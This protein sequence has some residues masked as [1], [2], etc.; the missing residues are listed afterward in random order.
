M[1]ANIIHYITLVLALTGAIFAFGDQVQVISFIAPDIAHYWPFVLAL[2][3]VVDRIGKILLEFL[4]KG[5]EPKADSGLTRVGV[6]N[7]YLPVVA[8]IASLLLFSGCATDP[9]GRRYYVGPALTFGGSYTTPEGA[10]YGADVH[11]DPAYA[12]QK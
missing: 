8:V 12:K 7:P 3:T 6:K 10:R 2:A 4:A 5:E 11:L 9:S 1:K